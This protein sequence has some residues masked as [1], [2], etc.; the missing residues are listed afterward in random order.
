MLGSPTTSVTDSVSIVFTIIWH[1]LDTR[2]LPKV[3][4]DRCETDTHNCASSPQRARAAMLASRLAPA[5][6]DMSIMSVQAL[7]AQ[8]MPRRQRLCNACA[9]RIDKHWQAI[10]SSALGFRCFRVHALHMAGNHKPCAPTKG[11][12]LHARGSSLQSAAKCSHM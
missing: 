4:S 11:S 9:A 5:H 6:W 12:V 8:R 2:S 1:S 7:D 10:A 3:D